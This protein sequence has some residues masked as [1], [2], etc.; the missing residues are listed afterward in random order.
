MRFLCLCR[1]KTTHRRHG[2]RAGHSQYQFIRLT[3]ARALHSG[4][5]T[6][7]NRPLEERAARERE[8]YRSVNVN[9]ALLLE[10]QVRLETLCVA[11]DRADPRTGETRYL[12]HSRYGLWMPTRAQW[13]A[14]G[15]G[16]RGAAPSSRDQA[17][18]L[19]NIS[20]P[21][22]LRS[23]ASVALNTLPLGAPPDVYLSD[24]RA[25]EGRRS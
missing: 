18:R 6:A 11:E 8:L 21:P 1:R 9:P 14:F 10:P 19:I 4:E 15:V 7:N 17:Q 23:G 13:I 5:I 25:C 24:V 20:M 22:N 3:L 16:F 12:I 2:R